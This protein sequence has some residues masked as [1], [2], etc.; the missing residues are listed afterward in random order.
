MSLLQ[1]LIVASTLVVLAVCLN[2]QREIQIPSD[3]EVLLESPDY[4]NTSS[5]PTSSL[6][7]TLISPPGTRVTIECPD[8]RIS[9][10]DNCDKGYFI[11]SHSGGKT[12]P[13]CGS[14]S[15]VTVTSSDNKLILHFELVWAAGVFQCKAKTEFESKP[16]EGKDQPAGEGEEIH[17]GPGHALY[18]VIS[19]SPIPPAEKHRW[20]FTV[21]PGYKIG[22]KCPTLWLTKRSLGPECTDGFVMFDIGANKVEICNSS[23]DLTLISSGEKLVVSV[24]STRRTTGMIKCTVLATTGPHF[25][26]YK[27]EP[28]LPEED[29]SEYGSPQKKGP[30]RTT[31]ECGWAN[32]PA[33]A[34]I[35][36]GKDVAPHEF[37]W[38]V[39][40]LPS[41]TSQQTF[42]GGTIVTKRHVISAAHCTTKIEATHVLVGM[43]HLGRREGGHVIPVEKT[44]NH[45]YYPSYAT[46]KDICILILAEEIKFGPNVGPACLPTHDP[47]LANQPVVAIGWGGMAPD[48]WK[49]G[50][51]ANQLKKA[52]LR[53]VSMDSCNPV[54]DGRWPSNPAIHICT[55]HKN[56]DVCFGDSGGPVVWLD[57][58]TNRY[59]LVGIPSACDGCLLE[60]PALHTALHYYYPWIL[61]TIRSNNY[62]DQQVC[63]KID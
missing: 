19:L 17:L 55:W 16:V 42:C 60:K 30:K 11:L 41:A 33:P 6:I 57:H 44:V 58:E 10:S 37:P 48:E 4:P 15:G 24:E 54:W 46:S 1:R 20:V 29:S 27:N 35:L 28:D 39:G 8:V 40:L 25:E 56:K 22:I 45:G 34:R 5:D 2:E 21:Q 43:N 59:T 26:Q 62:A 23:K 38:M 12:P 3:R 53:V 51:D 36:H 47:D 61:E 9:P 50:R 18:D 63:T 52:K 31:C 49:S 14:A 32:K 7:W 13:Y